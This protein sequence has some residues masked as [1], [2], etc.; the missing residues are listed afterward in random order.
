MIPKPSPNFAYLAY[1]DARLVALATQAEEHFGGDPN[2]EPVE[3]MLAR[4]RGANSTPTTTRT[5]G[6]RGDK[7]AIQTT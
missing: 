5:Y 3:V 4:A 7:R 1:H 2:D 6:A